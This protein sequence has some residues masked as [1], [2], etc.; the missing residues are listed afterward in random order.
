MERKS[1]ACGVWLV[2]ACALSA[3]REPTH[4]RPTMDGR[5]KTSVLQVSLNFACGNWDHLLLYYYLPLAKKNKKILDAGGE[6]PEQ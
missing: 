3:K 4:P 2:I 6:Q 1:G 5:L